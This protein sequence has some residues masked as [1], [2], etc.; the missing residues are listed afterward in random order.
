MASSIP[1]VTRP[2]FSYI[3]GYN[4]TENQDNANAVLHS[5]LVLHKHT[6]NLNNKK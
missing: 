3:L 5:Y 1:I 6:N 2:H 4:I